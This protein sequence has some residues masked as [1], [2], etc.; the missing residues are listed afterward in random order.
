[1][2]QIEKAHVHKLL[3]AQNPDAALLYLYLKDGGDSRRA[4]HKLGFTETRYACAAATLHQLGLWAEQKQIR[5][6]GEQPHYSEEDV[7]KTMDTDV[8]FRALYGEVQ[9]L[10]GKNL[11]TEE[12]KI[13]LGFVRYLGM[14]ADVIVLLVCY[15]KDRAKK[16]GKTRNPSLR[17]IEKEAYDWAEKGID[18]ME[19]AAA[20]TQ[21]QNLRFSQVGRIMEVLQI[22]GRNLTAPE[23]RYL[24]QWLEMGFDEE[25]IGLAYER[26]CL[27]TGGLAWPYIHKILTSWH[28]QGLHTAKQVQ[29]ERKPA[30]PKGASGELGDAELAAIQ[31]L[32][33][34]GV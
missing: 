22:R 27:N 3:C 20:Y 6:P 4:A 5:L 10:L 29:G 12:L 25:T 30:V 14:S 9:R 28:E 1:M 34:T 19:E 15:C 31:K 21:Q 2:L 11:T 7:L 8:D 24:K 26:S 13:L 16:M 23:K 32:M 18:T 17:T 33:K